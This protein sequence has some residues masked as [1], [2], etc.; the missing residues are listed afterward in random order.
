MF[1]SQMAVDSQDP[2]KSGPLR[3]ALEIDAI[4]D[5]FEAEAQAGDTPEIRPFLDEVETAARAELF[6]QL[7]GL[8]MSIMVKPEDR[9]GLP[10]LLAD[11]PEFTNEIFQVLAGG[12]TAAETIRTHPPSNAGAQA[13]LSGPKRNPAGHALPDGR[14]GRARR[15]GRDPP[16]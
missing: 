7:L 11:Y 8:Q 6:Q 2:G 4:C 5:R 16:G 13:V 14:R 15:D 9:P 10:T 12:Q 1:T 3:R